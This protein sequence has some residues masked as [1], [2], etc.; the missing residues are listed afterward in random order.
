MELQMKTAPAGKRGLDATLILVI[1]IVAINIVA[2]LL[3]LLPAWLELRNGKAEAD[4]EQQNVL[5]AQA[6]FT[7]DIISEEDIRKLANKAPFYPKDSGILLTAVKLAE[8][9]KAPLVDFSQDLALSDKQQSDNLSVDA[10]ASTGAETGANAVGGSAGS[11][12]VS[13]PV[14]ITVAGHMENVLQYIRNVQ[15]DER[16]IAVEQWNIKLLKEADLTD[17]LKNNAYIDPS[18]PVYALDMKLAFYSLPAYAKELGGAAASASTAGMDE[19]DA[20]KSKYGKLSWDTAA[21]Q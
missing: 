3:F 12:V 19:L 16:L 13:Q 18:L 7:T 15:R 21:K 4:L 5:T 14:H 1:A 6:Q 10:A 8:A 2:G 20:L 17:D 11:Q 9:S